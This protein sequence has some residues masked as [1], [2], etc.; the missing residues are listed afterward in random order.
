M[1]GTET[2]TNSSDPTKIGEE[3]LEK[4]YTSS[5]ECCVC[6]DLLYKPVVLA[7][8]H[9]SCF[10]C[11]H[12]GMHGLRSS[13]CAQCRQ[14]YIHFPSICSLLHLLLLKMEPVAYKRREKEVLE[15]ERRRDVYS[16][17]FGESVIADNVGAL[18]EIQ[19]SNGD[20]RASKII[21]LKEFLSPENGLEHGKHK[22]VSVVDVL[23]ALCNELLF[24]PSVLNCGHVFCDGCLPGLANGPLTC[25]VCQSMHP[26]EFPN[27][28]L[29]LDHF[30]EEQFPTEYAMRKE[31]AQL[32]IAE[33]RHGDSSSGS[34]RD[35]KKA[36]SRFSKDDNLL[37]KEDL[38]NV[39]VGVGCDS[40]GMYPIIGKRY[41]CKD[42]KEKIGFDLCETC[43]N[44][45]SKLPG[46]FNQHHTPDHEFKLDKSQMLCTILFRSFLDDSQQDNIPVVYLP[47]NIPDDDDD[48]LDRNNAA[49]SNNPT[50]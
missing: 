17:Q 49:D 10:W 37:L 2:A 28:C 26:G 3:N 41:K 40:C 31:K 42:C 47:D 1:S 29:D 45:S 36:D 11:V 8:G 19:N 38:Q 20:L 15:E 44:S 34:L 14:P 24:H 9:V 4:D 35:G 25:P 39:H 7:C 48:D 50:E 16:P 43:Y 23:C 6:L 12:K 5:F 22:Q 27:I 46:R 18:E 32:K 33:R 13:H 30:L 21:A